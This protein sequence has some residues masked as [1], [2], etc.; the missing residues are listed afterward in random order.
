[1]GGKLGGWVVDS[2][3][4]SDSDSGFIHCPPVATGLPLVHHPSIVS[5]HVRL[6]PL[7]LPTPLSARVH[8]QLEQHVIHQ[9]SAVSA[10]VSASASGP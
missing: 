5:R 9:L 1:M 7:P 4:E 8:T 6:E 10:S 2:E 3:S